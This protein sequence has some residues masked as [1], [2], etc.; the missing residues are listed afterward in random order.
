MKINCTRQ[1]IGPDIF[2]T[3]FQHVI[4]T[5]VID[6]RVSSSRHI[7]VHTSHMS[8]AQKLQVASGCHTGPHGARTSVAH[9]LAVNYVCTW[10]V[11]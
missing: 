11:C 2:K 1:C 5:R 9:G 6:V 8:S 10:H 7:S 3:S 4:S